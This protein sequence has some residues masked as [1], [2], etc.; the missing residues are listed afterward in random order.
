MIQLKVMLS[1]KVIDAILPQDGQLVSA[2]S[3]KQLI[4]KLEEDLSDFMRIQRSESNVGQQFGFSGTEDPKCYRVIF[5][6]TTFLEKL[7]LA[8]ISNKIT[9]EL[10]NVKFALFMRNEDWVNFSVQH[11]ES[12]SVMLCGDQR[13]L[14]PE[15]DATTDY[16]LLTLGIKV[17]PGSSLMTIRKI[18]VIADISGSMQGSLDLLKEGMRLSLHNLIEQA[19]KM[20]TSSLPVSIIFH[21]TTIFAETFDVMNKEQRDAMFAFIAQKEIGGGTEY[22]EAYTEAFK[23]ELTAND[24]VIAFTDG[25]PNSYRGGDY[26]QYVSSMLRLDKF[27]ARFYGF[28]I[29]NEGAPAINILRAIGSLSAGGFIYPVNQRNFI[30]QCERISFPS[31]SFVLTIGDLSYKL[32][33]GIFRYITVP[34]PK[35]QPF[36]L[37]LMALNLNGVS[38][39]PVR[40]EQI[41]ES[42]VEQTKDS[43]E[44]FYATQMKFVFEI[45]KSN[46]PSF[47]NIN[48]LSEEEI[49]QL[50]VINQDILTRYLSSAVCD[51]VTEYLDNFNV[52]IKARVSGDVGQMQ[53]AMD[54]LPPAVKSLILSDPTQGYEQR[55]QAFRPK[56]RQRMRPKKD[57]NDQKSK[58][59]SLLSFFKTS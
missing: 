48:A 1:E 17:C 26:A 16:D 37:G 28:Y 55:G 47:P 24:L 29:G 59:S 30:V 36:S 31:G 33:Y 51:K 32:D 44:K 15:Q 54:A 25:Q 20:K 43:L 23:E 52:L 38:C 42:S 21:D 27:P 56:Y 9:D 49:A 13:L 18:K 41:I 14:K 10:L 53:A 11:V 2:I 22:I 39:L 3:K 34:L 57:L 7:T 46:V 50:R 8:G 4:E 12:L 58:R 19:I 6:L 40:K 5:E 45:F 35:E